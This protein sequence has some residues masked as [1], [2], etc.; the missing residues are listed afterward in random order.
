M[1]AFGGGRILVDGCKTLTGVTTKNAIE[2]HTINTSHVENM[3]AAA[4]MVAVDID[5]VADMQGVER[6]RI[7]M[8]LSYRKSAHLHFYGKIEWYQNMYH[9]TMEFVN[10]C[11]TCS[12]DDTCF[13]LPGSNITLVQ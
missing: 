1:L 2:T 8:I 6:G 7:R 10:Y 3:Y 11:D 4:I 12:S 9:V 5:N 13:I